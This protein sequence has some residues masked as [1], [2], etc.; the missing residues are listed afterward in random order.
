MSNR[1]ASK[2]YLFSVFDSI[3]V[4]LVRCSLNMHKSYL[5]GLTKLLFMYHLTVQELH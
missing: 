1:H 4:G 2:I 5:I 3:S